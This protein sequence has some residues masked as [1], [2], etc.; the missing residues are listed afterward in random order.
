VLRL[1][2]A[3]DNHDFGFSDPGIVLGISVGWA[4]FGSEGNTLDE[5]LLGADRAMYCD[6][7]RRKARLAESDFEKKAE[8]VYYRVM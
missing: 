7:F 6:K 8:T 1:Q 4:S 2:G 3:I 5:L